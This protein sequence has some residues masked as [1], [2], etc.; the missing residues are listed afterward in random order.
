MGLLA[1]TLSFPS[2]PTTRE[3]FLRSNADD[4]LPCLWILSAYLLHT[5]IKYRSLFDKPSRSLLESSLLDT[6]FRACAWDVLN[7]LHIL[8]FVM[9]DDVS[10]LTC[11][12]AL[13]WI[14]YKPC[15]PLLIDFPSYLSNLSWDTTSLTSLSSL[16]SLGK[17]WL[18]TLIWQLLYY[19]IIIFPTWVW[20]SCAKKKSL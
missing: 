12:A 17:G 4:N 19:T 11:A 20:I 10:S 6:L 1:S 2:I 15:P 9:M 8:N 7:W 18:N 3:I 16:P 14:L 13:F 5:K